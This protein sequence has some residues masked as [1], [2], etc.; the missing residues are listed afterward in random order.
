MKPE[1]VELELNAPVYFGEF[2][3]RIPEDNPLTEKGFQLGRMLFYEKKLSGDNTMACASCHQQKKAFTDG[4]A[5]SK[6]IDGIAGKVSAM[7]LV[8]MLWAEKFTWNG[9]K[10]SIEEQ[11]V[12][13]V[14]NPI[15]MHTTFEAAIEKLEADGYSELFSEVFGT[16]EITEGRIGK[17]LS[18]FQRSLISGNS[19][20]DQYLRNEYQA[21]SQ[22]IRGM[23]LFFTHPIPGQLRGGNCGDCHLGPL[24]SGDIDGFQGFHNNGLDSDEELDA[25]LMEFTGNPA[26]KGRFKT[27][28]L[29][30]IA[31][32]APYMHDGRF[33]TLEEVL[34]HYNENIKKSETLDILIKEG[35]NE[36]ID[37]NEPVKLFLTDQEKEDIIAFLHMLTDEEFVNNPRFSN[38]HN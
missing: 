19:K 21:T 29:R 10:R 24:T 14:A 30:N 26:D 9:R 11:S 3:N 5:V 6:G 4:L 20:Y 2:N 18:Q 35:S 25:G 32:T 28:S 8:N 27:P 12:D 15:E 13:P 33:Q 1:P 23:Q 34:D 16:P 31:L 36:P 38:P 7:S 22:E 17:A 37:P